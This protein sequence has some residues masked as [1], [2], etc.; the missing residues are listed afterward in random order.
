MNY[1]KISLSKKIIISL[2][3]IFVGILILLFLLFFF[4]KS[5]PFSKPKKVYPS[6]LYQTSLSLPED[7][8][9]LIINY[10]NGKQRW[11]QGKVIEGMTLKDV[12]LASSLAGK[13]SFL[14]GDDGKLKRIEEF[15]NNHKKWRCFV[16]QNHHL[17]DNLL[18]HSVKPRE[19]IVCK[20]E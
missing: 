7:E 10:G 3:L 12:F 9:R 11:F 19:E 2:C 20:F 18:T 8:A 5:S 14:I 13:F 1:H 15:E 17:I 16:K 6:S 4:T